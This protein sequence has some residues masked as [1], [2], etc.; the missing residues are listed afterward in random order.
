MSSAGKIDSLAGKGGA[1]AT[2]RPRSEHPAADL[3]D[4]AFWWLASVAL[5]AGLWAG[6]GVRLGEPD[7]AAAAAY[8][9]TSSLRASSS[10]PM[11][12]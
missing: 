3:L 1:H 10:I 11:S 7:A 12:G 4:D 6:V 5:F 8:L 2:A 9:Q